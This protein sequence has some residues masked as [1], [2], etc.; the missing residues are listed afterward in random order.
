MLLNIAYFLFCDPILPVGVSATEENSLTFGG[1][2]CHRTL[3]AETSVICV[4]VEYTDSQGST[5]GFKRSFSFQGFLSVCGTLRVVEGETAIVVD[6]D[7]S[8]S[9]AFLGDEATEN[10][11]NSRVYDSIWS[12]ETHSPGFVILLSFRLPSL[13]FLGCFVIAPARQHAQTDGRT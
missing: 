13:I 1:N 11:Q 5:V 4:V 12:M 2:C 10:S 7:S 8:T 9:V 3:V 6:K